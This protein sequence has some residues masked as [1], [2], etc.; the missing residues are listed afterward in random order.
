MVRWKPAHREDGSSQNFPASHILR[1]REKKKYCGESSGK[2]QDY[3]CGQNLRFPL[4]SSHNNVLQSSYDYNDPTVTN[5]KISEANPNNT[6]IMVRLKIELLSFCLRRDYLCFRL[7]AVLMI[8]WERFTY[9][10]CNK[11]ENNHRYRNMF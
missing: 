10:L 11:Q 2:I 5:F 9:L 1:L 4:Y 8:S 6:E 7:H 3:W